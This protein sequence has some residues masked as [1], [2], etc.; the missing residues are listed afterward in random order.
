VAE[1]GMELQTH[2]MKR[3]IKVS[4]YHA[5]ETKYMKIFLAE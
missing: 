5:E 4:A 3:N 1:D 2:M